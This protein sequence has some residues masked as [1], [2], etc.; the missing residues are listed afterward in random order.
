VAFVEAPADAETWELTADTRLF[1]H[2][3]KQETTRKK[4]EAQD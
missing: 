3:L 4:S 2:G 1:P